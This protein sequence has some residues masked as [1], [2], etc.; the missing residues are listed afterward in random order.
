[1]G[2]Q[3]STLAVGLV[4]ADPSTDVS[5]PS[6]VITFP[7]EGDQLTFDQSYVISGTA[8]DFGGGVV[9]G[10]EVSVDGGFTWHPTE[11]RE[12]WTYFWTADATGSTTILTRAVDDS[13]NIQSVSTGVN[14]TIN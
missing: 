7:V 4:P 1:M 2:V 9:G 3:P 13:G 11:G 14:V 10:V 6:S 12:N 8:T 5:E